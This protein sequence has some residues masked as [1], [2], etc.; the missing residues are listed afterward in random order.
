MD[1]D[2]TPLADLLVARRAELRL[3]QADA[4][5]L[6]GVSAEEYGR[7]ERGNVKTPR[8]PHRP[9]I[10]RFLEM[11]PGTVNAM[12]DSTDVDETEKLLRRLI[13]EVLDERDA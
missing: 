9:G 6:I 12:F 4:G 11:D 10:A 13:R 5:E 3:S 1:N 2:K 8:V 7:W